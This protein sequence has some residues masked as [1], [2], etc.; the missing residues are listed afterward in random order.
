MAAVSSRRPCQPRQTA[1]GP[2]M[3]GNARMSSWWSTAR[4]LPR[5][6]P[7]TAVAVWGWHGW[8]SSFPYPIGVPAVRCGAAAHCVQISQL[9]TSPAGL[10]TVT[11]VAGGRGLPVRRVKDA[12]GYSWRIGT[13]AE[14]AWIA[15]G[16]SPGLTITAAVP[17][18]FDAYATVVLPDNGEDQERHNRAM[19]ALLAGQSAGQRWWLGYLSTGA[20]DMV[21]PGVTMATLPKV[22]LYSGWDY[23][24]V[25]AGPRQAATWR[26]NE[27]GSFW[28]RDVLPD[29][30]FPADRSWLGLHAVRRRLDLR[31][32][33][34]QPGGQVP[35]SP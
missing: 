13:D 27:T 19:L 1:C 3:A 25:E 11:G 32:R 4:K 23:V 12:H 10:A 15:R 5:S 14:V 22:I 7:V 8:P 26:R 9:W 33:A 30:M 28:W 20:D 21:C 2:G 17:P 29:L 24:V 35:G 16:T 18:V 6:R 34:R 31:R